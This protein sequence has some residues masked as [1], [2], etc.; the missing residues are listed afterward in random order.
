MPDQPTVFP[1]VPETITVHLGSPDSPAAN[2]TVPFSEYIKNV[3]SSEIYP[4]WSESALRA[5][6]LAITSYAL[7]RVYTEYY[8]SRGYDFDI[9]NS[10]ATDQAFVQGRSYFQNISQ[11]VDEIF[12]SY[13]RR[14]GFIEPL[15]A[16]FCN[17]TTSTCDG[18]SQWGSE[19]LAQ[20]GYDSVGILR[21]YYGDNIEIVQDAPIE[22]VTESYPGTPL[23]NGST[24]AFVTVIQASLNRIGQN[25]PAIP[26]IDPVNG[27]FNEQT[28]NAVRQF[29][30]IFSLDADGIVGRATWY[31]IIRIFVAV[32]KL[33]ELQSQGQQQ[34]YI[35][36]YPQDLSLGDRGDAIRQ[37]Q[38]MLDVVSQFIPAIPAPVQSDTFDIGTRDAV[39]AFQE[40]IG[41]PITGAVDAATWD[42]LYEEFAAV[43]AEV[44]DR[45][46]LFPDDPTTT[47]EQ[48]P[49]QTLSL[50]DSDAGGVL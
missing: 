8:R 47:L 36:P 33:A 29:Q 20:E 42:A 25:Y 40:Y 4:T 2:V 27:I 48:F 24:G 17:G 13:I 45:A 16:K 23:R 38:Y 22:G 6:I 11:I 35:G 28:E 10:T 41:L 44:F 32:T 39:R 31:Q 26:K 5:N 30:R 46:V 34:Y 1:F 7:N 21:H 9:T 43:E 3:A 19:R 18:L 15:A 50:G 49:G 14:T 37:L 12:D